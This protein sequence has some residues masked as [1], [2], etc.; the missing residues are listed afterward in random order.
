[1]AAENGIHVFCEKP[2]GVNLRY[3]LEIRDVVKNSG[4]KFTTG[5]NT[6]FN[7]ENVKAREVVFSGEL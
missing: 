4:I 3:A 2:I 1:L 6:R 5:F 7:P